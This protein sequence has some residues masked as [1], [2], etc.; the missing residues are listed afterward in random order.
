MSPMWLYCYI[1]AAK[2][3]RL[4]KDQTYSKEKLGMR[5]FFIIIKNKHNK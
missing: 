4:M 3:M 1:Y 2:T 5:Y